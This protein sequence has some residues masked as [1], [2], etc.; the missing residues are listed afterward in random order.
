MPRWKRLIACAFVSAFL[1]PAA[2]RYPVERLAPSVELVRGPVN[3]VLLRGGGKTLA[4]YGDPRPAARAEQVLFTHNRRDVVWAGR[5]LVDDGAAAVVPAAEADSFAQAPRFWEQLLAARFHDYAQQTTRVPVDAIPPSRTVRGGDR[6][7]W[8][9]FQVR[10]IDTPGYTRGA[11][12]YLFEAGGKRIACTGDLIY[13]DG[14]LLDL[15]SLQDAVPEAKTRG[16]H[17][18]AARA[19]ALIASL[20]AVVSQKPDIL[21]PARGPVI[22]NPE[23]AAGKLISRLTALFRGHFETDALRWY[24]GDDNLR[25]RARGVLGQSL[26]EWMP[27]AEQAKLPDWII[28]ID[29]SR[30]IVSRSGAALLVDCGG[31]RILDRVRQLRREGRFRKL[32]GIWVTHYHDD[33]TDFVQAAAAEFQCPVTATRELQDVL[34]NP[35]AYR[36]PA[37][38]ANPIRPVRVGAEDSLERWHEFE[39]KRF[40][41]PG[42]T[43]YHDG[44]LVKR[45]GGETVF[46]SGD[47]FTP[48]GI[49]DY[50]L[51]NRN[52]LNRGEGFFYCLDKLRRE[53]PSAWIVNQHVEPVFRF[54]S[55][56]FDFMTRSLERRLEVLRALFPFDDPNYGVDEQWVR[57]HPYAAEG[58]ALELKVVIRN[59]SPQPREFTVTPRAPN[60][61]RMEKAPLRVR[62]PGRQEGFAVVRGTAPAGFAGRA[63]L[64]ADVASGEWEFREFAEAL[65][66]VP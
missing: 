56:Q 27:M 65:V 37:M 46:F 47:S 41:F 36:L 48:S 31:R 6:I 40:Y 4:V 20:R 30:L 16:Y 32:D 12:S 17:G 9:G 1:L 18:Y 64:T 26:P 66:T 15:Y 53:A 2:E 5:A 10:V 38:T 35:G 19:G 60:G 13:G 51:L 28:A 44:L 59:H 50:C 49:D 25:I 29:N 33:H 23:A 43:L 57:F 54:T 22:R 7:E 42:Q 62:I 55:G 11:V 61:W 24:W 52:F 45:D 3:G 58:R 39:L 63:V 14:Q 34:E 8:N 21:V